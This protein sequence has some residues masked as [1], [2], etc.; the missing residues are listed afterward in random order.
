MLGSTCALHAPV[1]RLV[2][3]CSRHCDGPGCTSAKVD[4]RCSRALLPL[5]LLVNGLV[6]QLDCVAPR[7]VVLCITSMRIATDLGR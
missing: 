7:S 3:S 1:S 2:V 6:L 5:A 4:E